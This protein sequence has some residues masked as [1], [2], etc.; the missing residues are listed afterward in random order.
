MKKGILFLF[1][2]LIGWQG[3]VLASE[4]TDDYYDIATNYFNSNNY[5]KALEYLDYILQIEPDSLQAKT[6]RDKISPPPVEPTPSQQEIVKVFE[7]IE[8]PENFTVL[9]VPQADVEKMAYNS[10]YYNTKG[11]ELYS[12]TEYDQA[13][14]YFFKAIK[15]DAQNAQAYNNLAMSYQ[16]K[17]CPALAIKYF[18]KANSLNKKYTQPLVNLS[19][20]YKQLG[21]CKN[22]I[23]Y[24]NRAI[25]LNP[26]DYLAYY[27]MGD[28]YKSLE[29]YPQAVECFK[30]VLRINAKF[31]PAYLSLAMCFF[32]T[33]QFNYTLLALAQ[34][35]EYCPDSDFSYF[36]MSKSSL[37]LCHY[38]DAKTYID[39]AISINDNSDYQLELAKINYYLDDYQSALTIFQS[40]LQ[41]G[42]AS[43]DIFNYVGLCNYKLK[44]IEFAIVNFNKAIEL[45]PLRPI[46]YYNLAQC[47]KSMGDKKNYVKYVNSA[48][49]INP[50]NFQDFIDLSYIYYDNGNPSYAIN[51]LNNAISKYPSV[52]SLYLSKLK[53]YEAIGDNLH[54]NETKDVIDKRFNRR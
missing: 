50:I 5:A 13:I 11:Q 47:Y 27:W 21:D 36:M 7:V 17:N 44:N 48:T 33:E 38:A 6:L 1:L 25:Y 52:K 4:L 32:E 43:S 30:E 15:L 23:Y 24:L 39:K 45:D 28:Y 22:Q 3:C 41:T 35:N 20:L 9:N 2:V 54:Y 34:Y 16:M 40:L 46:Y 49:K 12:K 29:D 51:S 53:I 8:H 31:P 42:A 18:K 19:N 14:E 26:N 37:A 10:D